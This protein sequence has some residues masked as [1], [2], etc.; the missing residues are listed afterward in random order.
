MIARDGGCCFPGCDR[1]PQVCQAHHV[2]P[3]Q[4][5]GPTALDNLCSLCPSHHR[6]IEPPRDGD[7]PW[8]LTLNDTGH[9]QFTPPPWLDPNQQPITNHRH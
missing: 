9:W 5:G 6:L 1:P 7:P 4:Q 2:K 3:W 8:K